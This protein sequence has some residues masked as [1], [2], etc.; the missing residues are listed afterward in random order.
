MAIR[1]V[2]AYAL[3]FDQRLAFA[4]VCVLSLISFFGLD[5]VVEIVQ[6]FDRL[7]HVEVHIQR[8]GGAGF[9]RLF[10]CV[11]SSLNAAQISSAADSVRFFVVEFLLEPAEG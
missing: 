5:N 1:V 6:A 4:L 8:E 9:I 2:R 11:L 7:A 3:A 10:L